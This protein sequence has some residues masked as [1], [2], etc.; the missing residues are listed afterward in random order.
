MEMVN[1]TVKQNLGRI[2]QAFMLRLPAICN[3]RRAAVDEVDAFLYPQ[4]KDRDVQR[5]IITARTS[6]VRKAKAVLEKSFAFNPEGAAK[7]RSLSGAMTTARQAEAML[8]AHELASQKFDK[9][10]R[11]EALGDKQ[12]GTKPTTSK[13]AFFQ[14]ESKTTRTTKTPRSTSAARKDFKD[15][16]LVAKEF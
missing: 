1:K 16:S 8:N 7:L 5:V 13:I 10:L 9:V 11:F 14:P 3:S 4:Y 2:T 15:M 12:G 6:A